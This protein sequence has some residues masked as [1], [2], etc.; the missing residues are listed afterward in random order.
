MASLTK[1]R[2]LVIKRKTRSSGKPRKRKLAA[3]T[4]PRFPIHIEDD[5]ECVL[6]QPPGTR[7]DEI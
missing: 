7:K 5:P 4:T 1:Q 2:K 3:G 6:P